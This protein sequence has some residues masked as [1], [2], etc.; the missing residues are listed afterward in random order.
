MPYHEA[1]LSPPTSSSRFDL[2]LRRHFGIR[3]RRCRRISS[4]FFLQHEWNPNIMYLMHGTK[5][6]YACVMLK[7]G[8]KFGASCTDFGEG[9]YLTDPLR[10]ALLAAHQVRLEKAIPC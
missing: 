10:Y 7:D 3:R 6:E 2:G 1:L 9:W 5:L 8:P 4:P